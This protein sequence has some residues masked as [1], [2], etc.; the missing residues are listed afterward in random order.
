[1]IGLGYLELLRRG[2]QIAQVLDNP[3]QSL[4]MIAIMF[5]AINYTLGRLATTVER[6][7]RSSKGGGTMP[8]AAAFG[9]I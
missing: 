1:V 8:T 6:R 2:N 4:F 9:D 3:I 7:L 5:I